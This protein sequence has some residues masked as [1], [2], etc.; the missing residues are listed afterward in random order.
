MRNW[1]CD[2]IPTTVM[3]ERKKL[4]LLHT[5]AEKK[6]LGGNLIF[7]NDTLAFLPFRQ[8][9]KKYFLIYSFND[10]TPIYIHTRVG[11]NELGNYLITNLSLAWSLK[12]SL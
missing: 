6:T 5:R 9:R 7:N 3:T 1:Q 10:T 2:K 12:C 11:Y 4:N 8:W